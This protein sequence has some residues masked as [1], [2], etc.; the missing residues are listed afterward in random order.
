[1][2][3]YW[4]V[5]AQEYIKEELTEYAKENKIPLLKRL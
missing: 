5:S 3:N 1:M 2:T 4:E